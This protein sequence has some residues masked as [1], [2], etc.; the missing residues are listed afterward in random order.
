MTN[1][2]PFLAELVRSWRH[3]QSYTDVLASY[4]SPTDPMVSTCPRGCELQDTG[5]CTMAHC[6][7]SVDAYRRT[8]FCRVHGFAR[9]YVITGPAASEHGWHPS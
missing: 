5:W 2:D 4:W 6:T 1:G 9:I 8:F 3:V 7:P